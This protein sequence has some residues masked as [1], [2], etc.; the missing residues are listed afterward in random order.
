MYN[1]GDITGLN[2]KRRKGASIT[3]AYTRG[4]KGFFRGYKN[5]GPTKLKTPTTT[6]RDTSL[7]EASEVQ[8]LYHNWQLPAIYLS[9]YP[10]NSIYRT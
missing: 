5:K 6:S 2:R 9:C 10:T 8:R 3:S 1:L 7:G 4:V